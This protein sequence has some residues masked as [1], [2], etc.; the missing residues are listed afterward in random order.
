MLVTDHEDQNQ[1]FTS[2]LIDCLCAK[3]RL[4]VNI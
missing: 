2:Y 3:K 1:E 4:V